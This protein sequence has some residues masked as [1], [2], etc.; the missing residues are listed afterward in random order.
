MFGQGLKVQSAPVS[1]SGSPGLSNITAL[2]GMAQCPSGTATNAVSISV[3]LSNGG[4][5]TYTSWTGVCS[6][7]AAYKANPLLTSCP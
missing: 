3:A 2:S 7:I 1:I 5:C 6:Y 4:T